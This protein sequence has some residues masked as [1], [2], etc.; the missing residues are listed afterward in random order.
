MTLIVGPVAENTMSNGG[1]KN[2]Q[3][4]YYMKEWKKI[5]GQK[6]SFISWLNT[7][8]IETKRVWSCVTAQNVSHA[9]LVM[10]IVRG[11]ILKQW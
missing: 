8:V 2:V 10:T 6:I 9:K 7:L 4:T 5:I 11:A 3:D 1:N